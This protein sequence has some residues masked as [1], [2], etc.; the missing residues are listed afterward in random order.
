M[1]SIMQSIRQNFEK[2]SQKPLPRLVRLFVDRIFRGVESSEGE[3]DMSMGLVLSLLA[4][5][6]GFYSV[7]LLEKYSTLLQWLRHQHEVDP[8]AAALPDEYFFIV[9]SMAVTGVVA[10]WRW[11]SIFPD[12]RDYSNL[13]HL[14]ISTRTIFLANLA[15]VLLCA[16]P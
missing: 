13:V 9:L 3:L 14:P 2:V 8:L 5:P 16:W 11:D 12:R 7:F 10:V 1:S 6:G 4:L 15:A